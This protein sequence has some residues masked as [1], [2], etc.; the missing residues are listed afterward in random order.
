[1]FSVMLVEMVRRENDS[2][3]TSG[4][5]QANVSRTLKASLLKIINETFV[6]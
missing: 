1:M 3:R 6:N 5:C 2:C 4:E